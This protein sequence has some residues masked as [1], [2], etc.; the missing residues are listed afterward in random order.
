V[1]R[2]EGVNLPAAALRWIPWRE[3]N[4]LLLRRGPYL[5]GAGLD[6]SI[7]ADATV[8]KGRFIN[9]FDAELRLRR[10]VALEP[11]ARV[12]LLDLDA[13]GGRQ[14][15]LLASACKALPLKQ[16]EATLSFTVEGVAGTPAV[17]LLRVPGGA[18]RTVTLEGQ[19]AAKVGPRRQ[20]LPQGG[21]RVAE[22][23]FLVFG[24]A[25]GH[26]DGPVRP[27]AQRGGQASDQ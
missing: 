10:S 22:S 7:A 24:A 20:T 14:P 27:H 26:G 2:A 16:E 13:V 5:I 11:G 15:R 23:R 17:V 4:H 25:L 8:V 18:P 1:G 21:A 19:A 9:L 12:F 3:A 6:E